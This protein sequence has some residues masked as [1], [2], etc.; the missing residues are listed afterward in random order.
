MYSFLTSSMAA[1]DIRLRVANHGLEVCRWNGNGDQLSSSKTATAAAASAEGE[2]EQQEQLLQ[3]NTCCSKTTAAAAAPVGGEQQ[4]QNN[5]RSSSSKATVAEQGL[6]QLEQENSTTAAR[7]LEH[8]NSSCHLEAAHQLPESSEQ[9]LQ[10]S[11]DDGWEM[12]S[13][14]W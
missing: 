13:G 9:G 3:E 8:R 6:G 11:S 7:R 5:N 12:V 1:K 2:S 4:Q 14:C 10:Q